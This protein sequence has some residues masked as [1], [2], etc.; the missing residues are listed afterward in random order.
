MALLRYCKRWDISPTNSIY[1]HILCIYL[2]VNVENLKL[3][4]PSMLLQEKEQVIPFVEDLV[5]DVEVDFIEGK[6]L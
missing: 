1:P 2:V 4:E 5:P 6:V 3:Y